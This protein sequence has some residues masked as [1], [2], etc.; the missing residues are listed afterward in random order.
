MDKLSGMLSPD[1]SLCG[2]P[3]VG[4]LRRD[5]NHLVFQFLA[6]AGHQQGCSDA[7]KNKRGSFSDTNCGL[8][9]PVDDSDGGIEVDAEGSL[10]P[11]YELYRV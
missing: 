9:P 2:T 8:P 5:M 3:E 10:R 11:A 7:T 1:F 6:D 4:G